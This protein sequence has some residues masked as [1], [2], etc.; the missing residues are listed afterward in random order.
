MN[1]LSIIFIVFVVMLVLRVPI[2]YCLG[3]SGMAYIAMTGNFDMTSFASVMVR[4]VDSFP[5]M[6]VPFFILAGALMTAG[7]ISKQIVQFATA[8]V[9]R[10]T[11][12]LAMVA[13]VACAFFAALSG[14][15]IDRKSVV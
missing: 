8:L 14:S 11:G 2:A 7:G 10:V 6:A 4:S 5:L 13:V 3:L 9:G 15:G 12:G 1:G